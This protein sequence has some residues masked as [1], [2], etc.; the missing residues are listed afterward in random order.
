MR[1]RAVTLR[2]FPVTE[3]RRDGEV[4]RAKRGSLAV[5]P[6]WWLLKFL[7]RQSNSAEQARVTR[8]RSSCALQ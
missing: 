7:I 6:R 5:A 8:L 1:A 3:A 2:P 4:P